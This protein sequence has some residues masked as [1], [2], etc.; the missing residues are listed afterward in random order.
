[1]CDGFPSFDEA[2]GKMRLDFDAYDTVERA[3]E[4]VELPVSARTPPKRGKG[5]LKALWA[6]IRSVRGL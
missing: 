4:G 5:T 2:M 3:L 1:M 6:R